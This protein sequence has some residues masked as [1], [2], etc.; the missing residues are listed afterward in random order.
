M[1]RIGVRSFVA[2]GEPYI[3]VLDTYTGAAAAYSLRLLRTAYTGSA[4]RVRRS[5]DNTEQD[6]GFNSSGGLDTTALTT[7]CGAGNGFVTTWYDQSGNGR[8]ATQSTANNQPRIVNAGTIE[9]ENNVP[10]VVFDGSNDFLNASGSY[11]LATGSVFGTIKSIVDTNAKTIF[12]RSSTT[13]SS[14]NREFFNYIANSRYD[15]QVGSGASFPTAFKTYTTTNY[16]LFTGIIQGATSTMSNY[17]NSSIGTTATS[18]STTLTGTIVTSIGVVYQLTSPSFYM[19]GK[20]GEIIVYP[21]NQSSNRTGIE[22][23]INTYYGIY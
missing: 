15:L 10:I 13:V 14:N 12:S 1:I 11:S 7:F 9:K 8:N 4:I 6:I 17:I 3:G 2:G 18:L 21:S 20:I 5:S 19:N 16:S 22:S 23:N